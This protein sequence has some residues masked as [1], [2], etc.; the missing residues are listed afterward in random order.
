MV[1]RIAGVPPVQNI[2]N[3]KANEANQRR[4]ASSAEATEDS[5]ELSEEA[6]ILTSLPETRRQVAE[7][8]QPLGLD[9]EFAASEAAA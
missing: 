1:D 4:D 7:S 9:P 6:R 5:V 8:D 2:S 3:N